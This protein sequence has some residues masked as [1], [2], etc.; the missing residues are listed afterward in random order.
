VG[1]RFN[2]FKGDD[3]NQVTYTDVYL[4]K[5]FPLDES[6][7]VGQKAVGERVRADLREKLAQFV[8]GELV[9]VTYDSGRNNKAVLGSI[10]PLPVAPDKK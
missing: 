8:P 3:G 6:G 5:D 9:E 4:V 2:S 10:E 1:H 7:G